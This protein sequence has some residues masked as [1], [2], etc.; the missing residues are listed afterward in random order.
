MSLNSLPEIRIKKF[1][2]LYG[3]LF[4]V[5]SC[6][7]LDLERVIKITTEDVNEVTCSSAKAYGKIKDLGGGISQHGFCLSTFTE[8][9]IEHNN[10]SE[11]NALKTGTFTSSII[12]LSAGTVYYI[13]AYATNSAGTVYG[14]ELSFTT[15]IYAVLTTATPSNITHTSAIS[16]GNIT[17]DGGAEITERG[18][19]YNISTNPTM[20]NNT[21]AS[22]SGVGSYTSNLTGLNP[23]TTYYIRAY[24]I[25][26]TCIA[27]GNELSF[28][29]TGEPA[30]LTTTTPS[31]ITHSTATSGGNITD[32]GGS[33][34]TERGVC[35]SI[36]PNPTT[37]NTTVSSGS[38][39][40]S[41][42]SNITGLNPGTIYYIRAYAVNSAV[43]AYGNEL[44]F[45][46]PYWIQKADF[47]GTG[48]YRAVG[49]SISDKGY[50]GTGFGTGGSYTKDFWEYDPTTDTWTQKADFGGSAR[51]DAVGFSI[52]N[53]GYIG[54]GREENV[55]YPIDFWEY[56]QA[57]DTWTQKAG[58][59]GS[60]RQDAVGFSIGNK[61]YIGTG[62]Y[63]SSG[64]VNIKDFW[65]YDHT[66]D[67]W[68]QKDDFGGSAR[69][70][71][72]GFSIGGKGYIGTGY[73]GSYTKDF[74]EYDQATDIWTQKDDFGGSARSGAVG[75]SISGKG[76]IGTG[77]AGTLLDFW[78]YDPATNIWSQKDDFGGGKREQAVGFS[79]SDK[80]Y[81]G[82]GGIIGGSYK[83]D[84]WEYKP[85]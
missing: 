5:I 27:Y 69:S 40:G 63:Y 70:G 61:G 43:T 10:T 21:V 71:A 14:N 37:S 66:T 15:P 11:G 60:G 46:T 36:F 7:K 30:V 80:G 77:Y 26:N 4:I 67:S 3:I 78:E 29:T 22:G 32:E 9:T 62:E 33:A 19:C 2:L 79:I 83:K 54:T 8:P 38:G 76:Y 81:I 52:N 49:F 41:F 44:S 6:E 75:F 73:D 20:G 24:A 59:G 56:D 53:K 47:C 50:I 48:K 45:T 18:I 58:F 84:F 65:E 55:G 39:A 74:W 34:V 12:D 64:W 68:T 35:Y 1:I 57:T 31:N 13:R 85:D 28:T 17:N 72:V 82:I 16:G 25:N 51:Y 23:G 42:I